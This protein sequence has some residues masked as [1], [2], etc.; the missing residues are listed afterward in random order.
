MGCTD[1]KHLSGGIRNHDKS[2]YH[3]NS[4]VKFDAFETSYVLRQLLHTGHKAY[5]DGHNRK[6]IRI[7]A[8]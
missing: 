1:L 5:I 7:E 4:H 6:Y 2:D 8:F 3:L